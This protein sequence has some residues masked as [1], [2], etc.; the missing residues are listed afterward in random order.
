MGEEAAESESREVR[1]TGKRGKG[2]PVHPIWSD[3]FDE[4]NVHTLQS[5]NNAVCKHCKMSVR[6]HHKTLSVETH[7]RK[8]KPF[9]KMMM[10]K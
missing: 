1:Q 7:L 10:D 3:A 9:K 8:C 4:P 2:K 5:L 6:H